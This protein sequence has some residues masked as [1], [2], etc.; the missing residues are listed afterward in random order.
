MFR[1]SARRIRYKGDDAYRFCSRHHWYLSRMTYPL[2]DVEGRRARVEDQGYVQV[3]WPEHHR[4]GRRGGS[5]GWVFHHVI[6]AERILGRRL[7][8][9]EVVRHANGVKHDNRPENLFVKMTLAEVDRVR[10]IAGQEVS[11]EVR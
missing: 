9:G 3:W 6:V 10:R 1:V 7:E 2:D 4:A 11:R 5:R 8:P